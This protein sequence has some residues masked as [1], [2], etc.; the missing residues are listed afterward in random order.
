MSDHRLSSGI[1]CSSA[2][3]QFSFPKSDRF[4]TPKKYTNAFGYQIPSN[5]N[6]KRQGNAGK[7]FNTS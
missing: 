5:F 1:N 3:A 2:K 4:A 6:S 7:G